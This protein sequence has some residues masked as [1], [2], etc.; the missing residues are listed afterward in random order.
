MNKSCRIAGFLLVLL[1]LNPFIVS[2][3]QSSPQV[4]AQGPGGNF[5]EQAFN[6][7]MEALEFC[8]GQIGNPT[9]FDQATR[10]QFRQNM[11]NAYASLPLETQQGLAAA[12]QTW[13]NYQQAWNTI[14]LEQKKEFAFGV[15]ALAYGEQAAAQALGIPQNGSAGASAS[16]G[17][18]GGDS[19]YSQGGAG[20]YGSYAS[21][22]E[23]AIF[24]TEAGSISTCD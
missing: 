16:G 14:T 18:S 11:I 3:G 22:G 24:S 1:F 13:M 21:D 4:I 20:G 8:L 12:E 15:L 5:T 10:Q 17:G 19:Y 23:C 6:A 9:E 2:L 7:Y